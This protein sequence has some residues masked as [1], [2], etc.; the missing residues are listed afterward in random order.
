MLISLGPKEHSRK[1]LLERSK[2]LRLYNKAM[3]NTNF[4]SSFLKT[5]RSSSGVYSWKLWTES[6]EGRCKL[7]KNLSSSWPSSLVVG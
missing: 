4:L 2:K 5:A 7:G 3:K 1:H 6:S